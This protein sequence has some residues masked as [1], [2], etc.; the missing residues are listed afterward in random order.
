MR[1]AERGLKDIGCPKLNL[2]VRG[3]NLDVLKFY[4]ALG[5]AVEDRAS[6][7]KPLI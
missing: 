2:Q 4:E 6:L 7:G 3:S 5:Y 1:S